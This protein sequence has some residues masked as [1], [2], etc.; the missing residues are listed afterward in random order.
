MNATYSKLSEKEKA[1]IHIE[2]FE[3]PAMTVANP[4]NPDAIVLKDIHYDQLKKELDKSPKKLKW[5]MLYTSMCHGTPYMLPY[6]KEVQEK[7]GDDV[8]IFLLASDDYATANWVKQKLFN[9]GVFFQTYI[10]NNSYGEFKDDRQKGFII[11]NL[12]CETCKDDLIGV[13]YNL[14]FNQKNEIVFTKYRS[15]KKEGDSLVGADFIGDLL[16]K[17]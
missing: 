7:Y 13:P 4:E 10:I 5:V 11:R 14:V 9:Y 2:S 3:S 1:A 15:Y 16:S 17:Q 8:A 6:A 12:L